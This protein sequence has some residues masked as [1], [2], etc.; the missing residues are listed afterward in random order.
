MKKTKEIIVD[1][2]RNPTEISPLFINGSEVEIVDNFKFL[3]VQISN[4]LKWQINIDQIV[5][6][7]QQR[8]YFLRRLRSFRVSQELLVKFYRAVIESVLT[9]SFT[10]WYASATA[11]DRNRLNRIVCT[12]SKIVGCELPS[13]ISLYETRA[14]KKAKSILND[15][16]HPASELFRLL[17]SGK[18][19]RSLKV[20][21]QRS[22]D[23]FYPTAIRLLNQLVFK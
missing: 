15:S 17:P 9:F 22:L 12:A 10:V 19:L 2:R 11:E 1:F 13:L 8:L 20:D 4:D 6:K 3:G 14:V 23:S 7:T 5:C 16:G 18:R 21:S